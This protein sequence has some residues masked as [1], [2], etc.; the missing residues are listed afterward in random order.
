LCWAAVLLWALL[1]EAGGGRWAVL[2]V[3]TVVAVGGTVVKYLWP[4]RRLKSTGVPTSSLLAG[5]V[6]G[7][8][9]FF[10]VPLV[11][12]VLGFVLGLWLAERARL[13]PGEAWQSTRQAL[14]AVGLSMLVEFAA[15]LAIA[16]IW[17]FGLIA[18]CPAR[19]G[20]LPGPADQPVR[21]PDLAGPAQARQAASAPAPA[22]PF[23]G[24]MLVRS[25]RL[26]A[27]RGGIL[28][29]EAHVLTPDGQDLAG[30][31]G[32]SAGQQCRATGL[33]VPASS[34]TQLHGSRGV[35]EV[36]FPGIREVGVS[37]PPRYPNFPV[38]GSAIPRPP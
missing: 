3:A 5:G 25:A 35:R 28:C 11:G 31:S 24:L 36:V 26:R 30:C 22:A 27:G 2:A 8:I 29:A 21:P 9:G 19:P 20:R 15:A 38:V 18:A 14:A 1:G 37:H 7:L 4:G 10:V 13:G 17:I 12:L 34:P 16:V 33:S 32:G 23:P 6:V